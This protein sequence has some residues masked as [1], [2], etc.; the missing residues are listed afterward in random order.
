MTRESHIPKKLK[1]N[2]RLEAKCKPVSNQFLRLKLIDFV[3]Q[4]LNNSI[5]FVQ[6]MNCK[7]IACKNFQKLTYKKMQVTYIQ[8]AKVLLN[9]YIIISI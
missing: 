5:R 9:T 1:V 6:K 7:I 4:K 8:V 2:Y 3:A